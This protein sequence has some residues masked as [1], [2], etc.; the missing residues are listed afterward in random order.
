MVLVKSDVFSFIGDKEKLEKQMAHRAGAR[1]GGQVLVRKRIG[2]RAPSGVKHVDNLEDQVVLRANK[3]L[4]ASIFEL[5]SERFLDD[6]HRSCRRSARCTGTLV[7]MLRWPRLTRFVEVF[8]WRDAE[9]QTNYWVSACK[10]GFRLQCQKEFVFL[11]FVA[12]VWA[13]RC[14]SSRFFQLDGLIAELRV[15]N[16]D[17]FPNFTNTP[18]L[19]QETC[20][21]ICVWYK[22][23]PSY[24]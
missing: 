2:L 11:D 23:Y 13:C 1:L 8:C 10:A 3:L 6:F 4:I 18:I 17:P 20:T 14:P 9:C 16:K 5:I 15:Q 7:C 22:S 21:I 19:D 24:V 12:A